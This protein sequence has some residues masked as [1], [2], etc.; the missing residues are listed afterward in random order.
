MEIATPD[1]DYL[2]I[3]SSFYKMGSYLGINRLKQRI[4]RKLH[5]SQ[6]MQ[7][8]PEKCDIVDNRLFFVVVEINN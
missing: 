6:F 3:I 7:R 8:F 4:K 2:L 1:K 5:F